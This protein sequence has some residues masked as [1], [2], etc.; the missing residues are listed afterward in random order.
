MTKKQVV[1][2]FLEWAESRPGLKPEV[3]DF[4]ADG[5]V[6][7][8]FRLKQ[9]SNGVPWTTVCFE[10]QP[11]GTSD[12]DGWYEVVKR[13]CENRLTVD[14]FQNVGIG[15]CCSVEEL[16]LKMELAR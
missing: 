2:K 5:R 11:A 8:I 10:I 16:I 3:E 6:Y 15:P 13:K 12:E 9:Y 1:S 14:Q 4:D 7:R